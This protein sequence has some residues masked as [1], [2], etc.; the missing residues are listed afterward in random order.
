MTYLLRNLVLLHVLLLALFFTWVHG[1]TRVDLLVGVVPGLSLL[2]L[3]ALVALPPTRRGEELPAARRRVWRGIVRDP[4]LYIGL[5]LTALLTL[6]WANGGRELVMDP[7]SG[8]PLFSP[9]PWPRLPFCVVPADA[10]QQL[11]WFPP[12]FLAVL[13][14]RHGVTRLGKRRL[15][16]YLVWAGALLA[17]LGWVQAWSGTQSLL[18]LTP[19]PAHFFASFGYDNHAGA[20]FTLLF[21]IS[22]GFWFQMALDPE[23]GHR[24]GWLLIPVGLNFAGAMGSTSRAAMLL[25]LAL[26]VVG[27]IAALLAAWRRIEIGTRV[28]VIAGIV[29]TTAALLGAWFTVP[30]TMRSELN[31]VHAQTLYD[32]TIGA[33][34]LQCR[35]AWEM[36]RD[37]PAFGVGGWGF[38]QFV[39]FYVTPAELQKMVGGKGQANVHNDI[40]QFLAEHGLIGL[41]L[42][43]AAVAVLLTP[44]FRGSWRIMTTP[45]VVDWDNPYCPPLRRVSAVIYAILAGTMATVIHSLIDLPFRSP[46]ILITWSLCLACAP[47]FLPRAAAAGGPKVRP[48]DG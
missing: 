5:L 13:A 19:L 22:G 2:L 7:A 28:R 39:R 20:F 9:P 36:S 21:A 31:S 33:R 45:M 29:L 48:L 1:G 8:R 35:S 10:I 47:A 15:L 32:D 3:S 34:L 14:V 38:R 26:L 24:A 27:G 41:G 18:W 43:L 17:L 12:V 46:A 16:S 11:Y 44:I 25:S 42:L 40:L 37:Y 30:T 6:Q 4:L 23:E